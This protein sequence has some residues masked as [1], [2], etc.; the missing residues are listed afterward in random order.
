MCLPVCVEV[1]VGVSM[2]CVSSFFVSPF[3]SCD[4]GAVE[5]RAFLYEGHLADL[6][7]E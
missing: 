2:S 1:C 3:Y 5:S 6:R 7:K 4:D